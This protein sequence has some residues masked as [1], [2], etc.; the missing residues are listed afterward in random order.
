M[1]EIFG[2]PIFLAVPAII[3]ASVI[4]GF[5]IPSNHIE[6]PVI[7]IHN[8]EGGEEPDSEGQ[9]QRQHWSASL[10]GRIRH[11]LE[12]R[13]A[14]KEHE[15]AADRSAKIMT[16]ANCIIAVSTIVSIG[17]SI[18]TLGA[19]EGQLRTMEADQRPWIKVEP[20][21]FMDLDFTHGFTGIPIKFFVTNIGKSPAFNVQVHQEGFVLGKDHNDVLTEQINFCDKMSKDRADRG[22]AINMSR[23]IFLFPNERIPWERSGAI[24]GVNN[25]DIKKYAIEEGG[26]KSL[27]IWLLGCVIYD[28]GRDNTVHRTGFIFQI[29][30]II[31]RPNMSDAL[32]F[33]IDPS[34]IIAKKNLV[35]FPIPSAQNQTN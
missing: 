8:A 7:S 34:E 10:L 35:T 25:E 4:L 28:F 26:K 2:N 32:S 17:V 11:K 6:R 5:L 3:V 27:N 18:C 31:N 24:V 30:R 16:L 1:V 14:Y 12:K 21:T 22:G 15:T 13:R 20:E 33:G 19:I 23:G 9:K 29:A